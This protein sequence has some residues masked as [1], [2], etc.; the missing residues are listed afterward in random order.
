[1][2]HLN[3]QPSFRDLRIFAAGQVILVGFVALAMYRRGTSLEWALALLALSLL[4]SMAGLIRPSLARP[5]YLAWMLA[6]FP[7]GWSLSHLL[8][9]SV[10]WL[11]ITPLGLL[12]RCLRID[13][14][15][16]RFDSQVRSYWVC[17]R[18]APPSARYF[19][20]F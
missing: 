11:L 4:F 13:P 1:M 20:P 2:I 8:L 6:M 7:I 18:P 9:A 16:R 14:L 15:E 10:Y 17:R 3:W 19:R 12:L 5:I